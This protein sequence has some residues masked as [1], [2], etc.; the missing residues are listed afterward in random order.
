M[1]IGYNDAV[2]TLPSRAQT[3]R[4]HKERGGRAAAVLPIHYP[5]ALFYAFDVLP[6]EVWG[7]PGIDA[8]RGMAHIQPY[9]CSVARNALSFL[10]SDGVGDVD[11]IVAPHTCDSMQGLGSILI[12]FIQPRQPTLPIYLRRGAAGGRYFIASRRSRLLARPLLVRPH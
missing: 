5:R 7:P 12:D 10:L 11:L 4:E 8:T 3:I 1:E 9:V 6:V 2:L